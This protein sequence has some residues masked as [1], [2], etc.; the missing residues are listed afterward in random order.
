MKQR[1]MLVAM[2]ALCLGAT[3][4][5]QEAPKADIFGGYSFQNLDVGP[6]RETSHGWMANVGG[7]VHPNIGIVGDFSGHYDNDTF[8]SFGYMAGV[9]FNGRTERINPFAEALFGGIRQSNSL[10][11]D[12]RFA[13]GFG[14]GV[15]IQAND[16]FS[17]R[18]VQ[19]DWMPIKGDDEW[20]T[21]PI[22]L[23]F[24]VVFHVR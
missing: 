20:E 12:N 4:W 1:I 22:R 3:A 8:D 5:A 14:G 18:A 17:V 24:G 21:S 6:N 13:M 7:N 9:R 16:L 2:A 15:D 19:F 10:G 23:G 11:A